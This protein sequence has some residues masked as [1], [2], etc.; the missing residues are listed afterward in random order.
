MIPKQDRIQARTPAQLEQEYNFDKALKSANN[1]SSM[2]GIQIQNLNQMLSQFMVATSSKFTELE[3]NIQTWF[4]KGVPTLANYPAV[5]WETDEEK[6]NHIGD[7]YY[8]EDDGRMYLFKG[9]EW[10]EC[11]QGTESAETENYNVIFY[12]ENNVVI[13]GYIINKGDAINPPVADAHWKDSEGVEVTFPYAPTSDTQLTIF[14]KTIR[15]EIE[16][17][18]VGDVVYE[19]ETKTVTKKNDG[20]AIVGYYYRNNQYTFIVVGETNDATATSQSSSN[21]SITYN[22]KTYYYKYFAT[23]TLVSSGVAVEIAY[24]TS[25]GQTAKDLLDYYFM[26]K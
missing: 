17:H 18:N 3:G 26:V 16:L 6:A 13:A 1:S 8:N 11:Y 22:D 4:S 12:S 23:S 19:S 21:F 9:L 2:L 15:S 10:A 25:Y 7:I 14:D 24:N 5:E 20:W